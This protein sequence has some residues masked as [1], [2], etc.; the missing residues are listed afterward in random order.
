MITVISPLQPTDL[1]VQK[2][3]RKACERALKKEAEVLLGRRLQE[4]SGRQ[5]LIYKNLKVK[6]LKTR[7]GSCSQ[8]GIITLNYYLIQ[9]PWELIDY[10]IVHELAHTRHLNHSRDFWNLVESIIPRAKERRKI[11]RN[12]RPV[13]LPEQEDKLFA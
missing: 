11:I 13:L 2:A 3:A 1:I 6:R 8:D 9:L 10:V 5:A 12:Y 7:W 4:I